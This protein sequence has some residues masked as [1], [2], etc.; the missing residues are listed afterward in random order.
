MT[1]M[2][3]AMAAMTIYAQPGMGRPLISSHISLTAALVSLSKYC[4]MALRASTS[5]VGNWA[6]IC[7]C[8][9]SSET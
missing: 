7:R 5:S 9:L 3:A 1:T 8:E 4:M 2:P 6:E